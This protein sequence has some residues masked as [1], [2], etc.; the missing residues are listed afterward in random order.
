MR[1]PVVIRPLLLFAWITFSAA[2]GLHAQTPAPT[3]AA[4]PKPL[5][6]A[7][8]KDV[9]WIPGSLLPNRQ[10][11]G[12]TVVF[13]GP[14]GLVVMDTGRHVWQSRAIL[15]FAKTQNAPVVAIVNSH[16]HLDHVSGNPALKASYPNA[17]VYA[18][19]AIEE[20]LTGFL[21]S[22][23]ESTAE[24]LKTAG[25]PS[26]T[27]EDL[28]LDI[29]TITNGNALKPDVVVK[30]SGPMA[31]AGRR[32]Q[33]QLALNGPTAGDV[34]LY[35]P[36]TRIVAVGDLVT[37]PVPF[38]DTACVAGW[39]TALKEIAALPFQTLVPG[40]GNPMSRQEFETYRAA[41]ESFVG[42][43]RSD[44]DKNICATQWRQ[45]VSSLIATSGMNPQQ[46][47]GMATYYVADVLRANGGNSKSCKTPG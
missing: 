30:T 37:L 3:P 45:D 35:D 18:S 8:A 25:L 33:V 40:H 12:N 23:M 28:R 13:Q 1:Y 44:K 17:K 9:W 26:E 39:R 43:A 21:R 24:Y 34:W 22:S 11:D 32:M 5:P 7:L 16:W 42:C 20:A 4:L 29:A 6:Q 46:G 47:Q 2:F 36:L 38:L 27:A 10:P 41:F 31:L 15:D 14:S 19:D